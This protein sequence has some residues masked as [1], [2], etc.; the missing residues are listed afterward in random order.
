MNE[1]MTRRDALCLF[2]VAP[3]LSRWWSYVPCDEFCL[4]RVNGKTELILL[5]T[6]YMW[7]RR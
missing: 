1:W 7:I 4:R 5:R 3:I 6:S 2:V